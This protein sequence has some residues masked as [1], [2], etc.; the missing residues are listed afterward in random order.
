MYSCHPPHPVHQHNGRTPLH[1][2]AD[3]DAAAAVAPLLRGGANTNAQDLVRGPSYTHTARVGPQPTVAHTRTPTVSA[4][5]WQH[6]QAA[7]CTGKEQDLPDSVAYQHCQPCQPGTLSCA[8]PLPTWLVCVCMLYLHIVLCALVCCS[9]ELVAHVVV[10]LRAA[11]SLAAAS[12]R[13]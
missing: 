5:G 3:A 10:P 2:A 11:K 9:L 12:L 13:L 1:M 7:C 6:A 4:P 8:L